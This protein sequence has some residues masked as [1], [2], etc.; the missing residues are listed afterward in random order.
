MFGEDFWQFNVMELFATV[1]IIVGAGIGVYRWSSERTKRDRLISF[2]YDKWSARHN[3]LKKVIDISIY[4]NVLIPFH[5]YNFAARIQV[6]RKQLPTQNV[7]VGQ[8]I[9]DKQGTIP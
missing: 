7:A 5:A 3:E 2:P 4:A 9:I 6:G 8:P 1:A